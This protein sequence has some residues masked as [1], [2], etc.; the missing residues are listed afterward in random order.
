LAAGFELLF[1]LLEMAEYG[2][3]ALFQVFVGAELDDE[4]IDVVP[5]DLVAPDVTSAQEFSD[6]FFGSRVFGDEGIALLGG[7]VVG[8]IEA[9]LD[10]VVDLDVPLLERD[11]LSFDEILDALA[12]FGDD[13]PRLGIEGFLSDGVG[14]KVTGGVGHGGEVIG[15]V[16]RHHAPVWCIGGKAGDAGVCGGGSKVLGHA[17]VE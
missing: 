3:V 2:G 10:A 11:S 17:E 13:H 1:E 15:G 8:F 9:G 4:L 5:V 12:L 14:L 6:E 7:Q 16:A